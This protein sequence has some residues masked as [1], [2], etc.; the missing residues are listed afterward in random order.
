MLLTHS[1]TVSLVQDALE[2]E[3]AISDDELPANVDLNDP[4]F[5]EE[6]GA[7]G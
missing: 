5:S 3:P 1:Y 6:L 7:T 2:A 4:F